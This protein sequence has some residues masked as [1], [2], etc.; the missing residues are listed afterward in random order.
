MKY[1]RRTSYDIK[2]NFIPNLLKDRGIINED[3]E[4]IYFHPTEEVR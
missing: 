2:D 4:E 3:N 1:V